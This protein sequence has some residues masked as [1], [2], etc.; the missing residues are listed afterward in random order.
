MSGISSGSR[1]LIADCPG[2]EKGTREIEIYS[3]D[4]IKIRLMNP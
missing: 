4:H 3:K 2:N 1:S